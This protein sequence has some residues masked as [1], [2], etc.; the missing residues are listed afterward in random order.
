MGIP[1][2]VMVKELADAFKRGL[3]ERFYQVKQGKSHDLLVFYTD[4]AKGTMV[5]N[6][7]CGRITVNKT[8]NRHTVAMI[9]EQV[10][11]KIGIDVDELESA[12][13]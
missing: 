4:V 7:L 11:E 1:K 8:L 6:S 10:A 5:G 9:I 13:F 2:T 12:M 3:G